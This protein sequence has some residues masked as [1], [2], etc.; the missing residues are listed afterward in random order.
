MPNAF[1]LTPELSNTSGL[2]RW[3]FNLSITFRRSG[4]SS[5]TNVPNDDKP[6]MVIPDDQHDEFSFP[7][8]PPD[9]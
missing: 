9:V 2:R 6:A 3:P 7:S 8:N 1:V 4:A 5:A